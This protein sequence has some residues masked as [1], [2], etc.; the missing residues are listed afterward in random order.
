MRIKRA[1]AS[2]GEEKAAV[3]R[4]TP[5]EVDICDRDKIVRRGIRHGVLCPYG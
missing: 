2:L 5:Q 1:E 3:S 4:R